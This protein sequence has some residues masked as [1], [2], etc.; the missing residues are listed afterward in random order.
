MSYVVTACN[1]TI[2]VPDR[3]WVPIAVAELRERHECDDDDVVVAFIAERM[4]S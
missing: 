3:S 4:A 1:E 2:V